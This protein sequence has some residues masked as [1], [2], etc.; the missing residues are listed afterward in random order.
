LIYYKWLLTDGTNDETDSTSVLNRR[1]LKVHNFA[2]L[3]VHCGKSVDSFW[4][5]QC[6]S[7]LQFTNRQLQ[8]PVTVYISILN[9]KN[10]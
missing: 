8:F 5:C 2:L 3:K 1:G 6:N 7:G 9:F 10:D 4:Q